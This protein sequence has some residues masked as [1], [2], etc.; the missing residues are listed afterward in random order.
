VPGAQIYVNGVARGVTDAQGAYAISSLAVGDYTVAPSAPG[1]TFTPVSRAVNLGTADAVNINFVASRV[2]TPTVTVVTV[3]GSINTAAGVGVNN[4]LLIASSGQ[5]ARTNLFG[6]YVLANLP[7][8]STVTVTPTGRAGQTFQPASRT[9]VLTTTTL[10]GINF[11][12]IESV[13]VITHVVR[14]PLLTR[15]VC[16]TPN[17][18]CGEPNDRSSIAFVLP[19]PGSYFAT[20]AESDLLDHYSIMLEQGKTY[21]FKLDHAN[22]ND[23]DLF[24]YRPD[25]STPV[26]KSD[27]SGTVD[28]QIVWTAPTTDRYIVLVRSVAIRQAQ[29]YQLVLA[30]Q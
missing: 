3:T 17:Q 22:L 11:S 26:A 4:I 25:I 19:G 10:T 18:D 23:L 8:N 12:M 24:I 20:L 30:P 27:A 9:L 2:T 7:A 5:Q 28:E 15:F 21:L 16:S 6:N 13:G 29:S 14:L 1:Y